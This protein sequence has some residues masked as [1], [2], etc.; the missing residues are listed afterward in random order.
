[1]IFNQPEQKIEKKPSGCQMFFHLNLVVNS[2]DTN[3]KIKKNE[4]NG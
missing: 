2:I 3:Q 4:R 1:V